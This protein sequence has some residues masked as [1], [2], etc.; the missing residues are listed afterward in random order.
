[1]KVAAITGLRTEARLAHRF[2]LV[3]IASGGTAARTRVV[4]ESLLN[5]GAAALLSFGIA[6]ALAPPLASGTLLLPRTVIEEN[7][8]RHPVD[9]AWRSRVETALAATGLPVESGAI[10]GA[11]QAA[12]TRERKAA[13]FRSTGA[14]AIDL[15]SHLVA[16]VAAEAGRPFLVLRAIAD[17]ALRALPPA[18]VNG[19]DE[20]GAPALG[21]V[22]AS[23]LR[24]PGQVPVLLR[25]AGDVRRALSAL[26]S[27]L[28]TAAL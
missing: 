17:P 1:M 10:L 18:A 22:L 28:G 2:G 21:R 9:G 6:G 11:A 16:R 19:L 7:G 4:S 13:L 12:D 26:S 3:A 24:Q 27:A 20:R 23:V 8:D 14:V 5:E 15:E 25:L